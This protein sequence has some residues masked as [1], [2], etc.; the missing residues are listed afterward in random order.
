ML[1]SSHSF[2]SCIACPEYRDSTADHLVKGRC[3]WYE[4]HNSS[5]E[6]DVSKLA[7]RAGYLQDMSCMRYSSKISASYEQL[8]GFVNQEQG[9]TVTQQTEQEKMKET[10][11]YQ[12]LTYRRQTSL[13]V[14][15]SGN[16]KEDKMEETNYYTTPFSRIDYSRNVYQSLTYREPTSLQGSGNDKEDK[17]DGTNYYDLPFSRQDD[18]RNVY[19]S[20]TYREPTSLHESDCHCTENIYQ[21]LDLTRLHQSQDSSTYQALI[22]H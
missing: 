3:K 18:S 1:A 20:L 5:L 10:N 19:Q 4:G 9:T 12:S 15:G 6:D 7:M 22:K 8:T 14:Q 2:L 21:P 11:Y 17:M 13:P 16:D